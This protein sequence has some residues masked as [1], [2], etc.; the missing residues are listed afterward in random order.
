MTLYIRISS[1]SIHPRLWTHTHWHIMNLVR[2]TYNLQITARHSYLYLRMTYVTPH[3]Q[4][5]FEILD[6]SSHHPSTLQNLSNRSDLSH[7]TRKES[8]SPFDNRPPSDLRPTLK[9]LSSSR[10]DEDA[11]RLHDMH[12]TQIPQCTRARS[13]PSI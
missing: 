7:S 11:G 5:C 10:Q 13:L 2:M 9:L 8:K 1:P 4:L 6:H 12:P 3:V